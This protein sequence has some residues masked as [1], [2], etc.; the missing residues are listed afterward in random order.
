[1]GPFILFDIFIVCRVI[2]SL[3]WAQV[4]NFVQFVVRLF[5]MIIKL[6]VLI[7]VSHGFMCPVIPLCL[8][9]CMLI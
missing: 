8:M 5:W 7:C 1:M 3:I 6:Y 4:W 9:I 2:Y